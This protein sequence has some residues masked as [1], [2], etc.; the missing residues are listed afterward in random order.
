MPLRRIPL[1]DRAESDWEQ[2]S[3]TKFQTWTPL[4]SGWLD[5][6]RDIGWRKSEPQNS[7]RRACDRREGAS[8]KR[9]GRRKKLR[10]E[11]QGRS[12]SLD[13]SDIA[14]PHPCAS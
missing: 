10:Q 8:T 6:A 4:Q 9:E 12:E 13:L 3:R 11:E 2:E 7:L 1:I 14:L 5:P